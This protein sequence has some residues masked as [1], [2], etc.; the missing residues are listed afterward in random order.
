MIRQIESQVILNLLSQSF[1]KNIEPSH[2]AGRRNRLWCGGRICCGIF[3]TRKDMRSK[4]SSTSP[5]MPRR[6][7][8]VPHA[9]QRTHSPL[10]LS[11]HPQS[12]PHFPIRSRMDLPLPPPRVPNLPTH[13]SHQKNDD[14]IHGWLDAGDID[15][16]PIRVNLR[17]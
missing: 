10:L 9:T 12:N 3:E 14:S 11:R 1:G 16:L 2:L 8:G 17:A 7:C 15:W 5:R 4:S 13:P 6:W